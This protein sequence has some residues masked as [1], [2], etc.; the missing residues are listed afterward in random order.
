MTTCSTCKFWKVG[1]RNVFASEEKFELTATAG[2]GVCQTGPMTGHATPELF[3]CN[4]YQQGTDEDHI[5]VVIHNLEAWQIWTMIPCP[6][7]Q[8]VGNHGGTHDSV[9]SCNRCAGTGNVRKYAD[10]YV[11]DERTRE[12]PKEKELR[13]EALKVKRLAELEAEL[14]AA[15]Q[16]PPV[17]EPERVG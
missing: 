14:A 11:G 3:G 16:P 2:H 17:A 12:H 5:E 15:T 8:A 7:C 4:N 10:G 1:I 13:L 9:S 6:D